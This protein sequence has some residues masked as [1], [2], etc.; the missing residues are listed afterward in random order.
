MAGRVDAA[1]PANWRRRARL[2]AGGALTQSAPHRRVA[3]ATNPRGTRDQPVPPKAPTGRA[4]HEAKRTAFAHIVPDSRPR[5]IRARLYLC[6]V[7]DDL[8]RLVSTHGRNRA[9]GLT[10]RTE[11]LKRLRRVPDGRSGGEKTAQLARARPRRRLGA[12]RWPRRVPAALLGE[13]PK[14]APRL[15]FFDHPVK[16]ATA[17]MIALA[18]ALLSPRRIAVIARS[19]LRWRRFEARD[20]EAIVSGRQRILSLP[21]T[22][23]RRRTEWPHK[24]RPMA[25]QRP[26][27][28]CLTSP[29]VVW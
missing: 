22:S 3:P 27:T 1:G 25:G 26:G 7:T 8:P 14:N 21:S 9:P 18:Q 15:A 17:A 28:P 12:H 29:P 6:T 16:V 5:D 2:P 20:A 23:H 10:E 19:P 11:Q 24:G 13:S 4:G